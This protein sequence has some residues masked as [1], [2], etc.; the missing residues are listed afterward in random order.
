MDVGTSKTKQTV[1]VLL[2]TGSFELWVNPDCDKSSVPK[3]CRDFGHYDPA[4]SSTSRNLRQDF[5]IRY[6]SGTTYG[7]YYRDDI[8]INGES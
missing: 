3:L 4:R 8:Y 7:T 5:A 2:D 6:G 1:S